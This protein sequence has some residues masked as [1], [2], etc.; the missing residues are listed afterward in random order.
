MSLGTGQVEKSFLSCMGSISS[1]FQNAEKIK[2]VYSS[3]KS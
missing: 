3:N 2:P 1:I